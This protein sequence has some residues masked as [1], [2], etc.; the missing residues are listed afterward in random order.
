MDPDE[1]SYGILWTSQGKTYPKHT[2]LWI[3]LDS[4]EYSYGFLWIPLEQRRKNN[5]PMDSFGFLWIPM[6][7]PLDSYG[8]IWIHMGIP[9]DSMDSFGFLLDSYRI[10]I[11]GFLV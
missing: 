10:R 2:Q 11:I 6:R 9:M 4:Y 8:F 7:I 3:P 1:Y 5:L